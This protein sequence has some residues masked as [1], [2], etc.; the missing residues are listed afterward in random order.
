MKLG[1]CNYWSKP[2][3]ICHQGH[4]FFLQSLQCR[5]LRSMAPSL[6]HAIANEGGM[7]VQILV[8]PT[9]LDGR[10][11]TIAGVR[12]FDYVG[13]SYYRKWSTLDLPDAE[14]ALLRV[15]KRF[16]R[17]IIVVEV[18]YPFTLKDAGD[19]APKS[20][21][22]HW[23]KPQPSATSPMT[24]SSTATISTRS[25]VSASSTSSKVLECGMKP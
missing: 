15:H 21:A 6:A 7:P 25:S 10:T 3:K 5:W 4:F 22:A 18:S 20:R 17:P 19:K 9:A 24:T 11:V 23:E 13:V 8:G 1:F 12:D 2:S 14:K 16:N